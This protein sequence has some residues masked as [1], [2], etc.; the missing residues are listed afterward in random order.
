VDLQ[1]T[2]TDLDRLAAVFPPGAAQGHRYH[3]AMVGLLNG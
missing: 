1:L 3:E 2:P